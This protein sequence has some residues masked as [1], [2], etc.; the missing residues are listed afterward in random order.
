VNSSPTRTTRD[1]SF[2]LFGG[3][4]RPGIGWRATCR[5]VAEYSRE[6][7]RWLVGTAIAAVGVIVAAIKL[8]K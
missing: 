7:H 1:S 6:N 3:H 8:G 4:Q 2:V 5:A